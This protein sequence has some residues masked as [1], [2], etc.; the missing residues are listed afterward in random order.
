MSQSHLEEDDEHEEKGG[1]VKKQA[2]ANCEIKTEDIEDVMDKRSEEGKQTKVIQKE[3]DQLRWKN[4]LRLAKQ[5]EEEEYQEMIEQYKE[6]KQLE[7]TQR[8]EE[9]QRISQREFQEEQ[10][11]IR[12]LQYWQQPEAQ[13]RELEHAAVSSAPQYAPAIESP[14]EQICTGGGQKEAGPPFAQPTRTILPHHHRPPS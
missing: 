7:E 8:I 6:N 4:E 2:K 9:A 5:K 1:S 12:A 11:Q 10:R 3:K 14:P 13:A